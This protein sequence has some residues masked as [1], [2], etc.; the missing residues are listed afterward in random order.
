MDSVE[1]YF[2][3]SDPDLAYKKS[4][5]YLI[6]VLNAKIK[7]KEPKTIIKGE[8][9]SSMKARMSGVRKGTMKHYPKNNNNRFCQ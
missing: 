7:E 6:D 8:I 1:I 3:N 4:L 2:D 5:V 9:G